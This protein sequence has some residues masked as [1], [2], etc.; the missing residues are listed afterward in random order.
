MRDCRPC[1]GRDREGVAILK[2]L[3][4]VAQMLAIPTR[5]IAGI[6]DPQMLLP[7]RRPSSPTDGRPKRCVE[8][9]LGGRRCRA[10]R[11]LLA[12]NSQ[13]ARSQDQLHVHVDCVAEPV[14]EALADYRSAL[15]DQ[16][17]A[18]TVPLRG[19]TYFARGSI[20]RIFPT[21]RRSSCSPTA[22]MERK[23]IWTHDALAAVGAT[24][25]ARRVSSC[26]P[27]SFH[28]KGA[29]T[30]RTSRTT[31]ARSCVWTMIDSEDRA[32]KPWA[33]IGPPGETGY[34]RTASAPDDRIATDHVRAPG[35]RSDR[36][37]FGRIARTV[38]SVR[39]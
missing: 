1:R 39:W 34:F 26:S 32:G 9:R 35:A 4:G 12:I 33:A 5:R 25:T 31:I 13:W 16:W 17:R 3:V 28:S 15:D 30:P 14:A 6:E 10:R 37:K 23:P 7:T 36:D 24:S 27:T 2:D 18:M 11:S 8:A 29:A 21:P 20:R 38:A 19:R 22:S